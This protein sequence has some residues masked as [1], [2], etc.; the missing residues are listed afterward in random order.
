MNRRHLHQQYWFS[1]KLL[2][3]FFIS[4]MFL[5]LTYTFSPWASAENTIKAAYDLGGITIFDDFPNI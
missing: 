4:L 2:K 1:A 5:T 3:L